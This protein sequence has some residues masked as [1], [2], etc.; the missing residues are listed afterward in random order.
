MKR[1]A[2]A[3]SAQVMPHAHANPTT[4]WNTSTL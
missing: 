3:K 4:T 1:F 2:I